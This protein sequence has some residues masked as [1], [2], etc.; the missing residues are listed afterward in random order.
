MVGRSITVLL[1]IEYDHART[2]YGEVINASEISNSDDAIYDVWNEF[3][4]RK[5]PDIKRSK[6]QNS[7]ITDD[8]IKMGISMYYKRNLKENFTNHKQKKM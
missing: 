2:E 1:K 7:L 8:D 5:V 4:K 6:C 3:M